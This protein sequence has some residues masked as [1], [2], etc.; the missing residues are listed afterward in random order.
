MPVTREKKKQ[1]LAALEQEFGRAG[2]AIFTDFRG[3]DVAGITD[4]RAKLRAQGA[5]YVVAKRTIIEK[6]LPANEDAKLLIE[7]D[8][9]GNG[10]VVGALLGGAT[11]ICFADAEPIVV[12]KIL[13]DFRKDYAAFGIKGALLG[14]KFLD[15]AAVGTLATTPSREALLGR[16]LGAM[17]GP[18]S[19]FVGVL[20]GVMRQFVGTLQAI[21]DQQG[22]A[23]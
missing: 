7:L 19:Q 21:A 9:L 14:A 11:G 22:Q 6:A 18:A 16:L 1:T 8:K 17:N 4:L 23:A 13:A 2:S 3:V 20:A 12:A 10:N 5:R 15:A